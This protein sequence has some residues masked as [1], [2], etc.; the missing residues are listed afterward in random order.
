MARSLLAS[1]IYRSARP[2]QPCRKSC[3]E[4]TR[5]KGAAG[6]GRINGCGLTVRRKKGSKLPNP[7]TDSE[8]KGTERA[9]ED[10]IGLPG[11]IT[12]IECSLTCQ[13][14]QQTARWIQA[15]DHF[16]QELAY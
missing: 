6:R 11:S 13:W 14:A 3:D 2:D 8:R 9:R 4:I 5:W 15:S 12:K 10:R 1:V 16:I 7:A